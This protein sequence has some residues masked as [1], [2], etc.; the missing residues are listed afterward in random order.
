[1]MTTLEPKGVSPM[2]LELDPQGDGLHLREV[3]RTVR[4]WLDAAG[5]PEVMVE[6]LVL[7]ASEACANVVDHSGARATVHCPAGWI[8]GAISDDAVRIVVTD[9]GRWLHRPPTSERS[10]R[11]RGLQLMRGLVDDMQLVT[12]AEGTTVELVRRRMA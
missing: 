9:R 3:R 6:E 1:M 4:A 10:T 7:A 8:D 11:G 5:L 2:R 12:G